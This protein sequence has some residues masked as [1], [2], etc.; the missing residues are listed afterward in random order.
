MALTE[1]EKQIYIAR[2]EMLISNVRLMNSGADI[3][4]VANIRA[5]AGILIHMINH[6]G[7]PKED[8]ERVLTGIAKQCAALF[9]ARFLP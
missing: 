2:A 4:I 8:C 7:V 5:T 1:A 6:V 3:H 9:K